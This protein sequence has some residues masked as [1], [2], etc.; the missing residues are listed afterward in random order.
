MSHK[1]KPVFSRGAGSPL[2][3]AIELSVKFSSD[4]FRAVTESLNLCTYVSTEY[5]LSCEARCENNLNERTRGF[6]IFSFSLFFFFYQMLEI[7]LRKCFGHLVVFF[8]SVKLSTQHLSLP[9]FSSG[10]LGLN[11]Q[12][13]SCGHGGV[14]PSAPPVRAALVRGSI[15]RR[16]VKSTYSPLH[17]SALFQQKR[18]GISGGI[19]W[20]L[21]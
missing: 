3:L 4:C 14:R 15:G 17:C 13:H 1:W 7:R 8:S 21:L 18:L 19:I 6:F 9:V 11:K 10:T 2:S 5:L 20:S 16:R 12:A